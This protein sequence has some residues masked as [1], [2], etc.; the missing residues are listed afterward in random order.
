[1][2]SNAYGFSFSMSDGTDAEIY[3]KMGSTPVAKIVGGEHDG[4]IVYLNPPRGDDDEE[5]NEGSVSDEDLAE[6]EC[7][8]CHEEFD[9]ERA[10]KRHIKGKC[11]G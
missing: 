5:R 8:Y 1:M 11:K 3:D 4:M 2:A 10:L 7:K 6:F 9:S